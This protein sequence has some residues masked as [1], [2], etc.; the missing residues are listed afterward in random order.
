MFTKNEGLRTV[1]PNPTQCSKC[2]YVLDNVTVKDKTIDRSGYNMCKRYNKKPQGV[3]W[4]KKDCP[5]FEE[6]SLR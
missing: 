5:L 6:N 3:L 2:I 4:N 1:E